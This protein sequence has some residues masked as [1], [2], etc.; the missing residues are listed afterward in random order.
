M[1]SSYLKVLSASI[2][3]ALSI[4][5]TAFTGDNENNNCSHQHCK[6]SNTH[7]VVFQNVQPSTDGSIY[8]PPLGLLHQCKFVVS[9]FAWP[10]F[11]AYD[12]KIRV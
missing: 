10:P 9:H 5:L 7:P 8:L 12:C 6:I 1:K 3:V 2:I 4:I 11:C